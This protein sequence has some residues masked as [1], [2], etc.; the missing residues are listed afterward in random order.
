[1]TKTPR[2]LFSIGIDLGTSNCAL[3]YIDLAEWASAPSAEGK[4][5]FPDPPGPPRSLSQILEIPQWE[6][7]S[8]SVTRKI[9]PSFALIGGADG[10]DLPPSAS[11]PVVGVL[12]RDLSTR[13]PGRIIASAKSW[14]THAGVDRRAKILPWRSLEIPKEQ[15][16]SP[17]EASAL[18]LRYLR[19]TWDREMEERARQ[20]GR[21][22]AACRF[23]RQHIVITVP[24]SF[25][26]AA[27]KLTLEAAK[28]AGYPAA[29]R[30]LEEP[31]AA[32][33]AW[34][35]R[36]REPDALK[37]ALEGTGSRLAPGPVPE[38]GPRAFH[39]LVVDIGGGT[40]DFSLFEVAFPDAAAGAESASLQI[41]RM[42]VSDHI[43]LGGDNIDLAIAHALEAG[44]SG[45]EGGEDPLDPRSWQKLVGESRRLK[46]KALES[47]DPEARYQVGL[48]G[49]G[50][51]LFAAAKTLSLSGRDLLHLVDEGFFPL[52]ALSEGPRGE[53]GGFRE[54]GLPY[55]RDSAITRHLAAFLQGFLGAPE[56]EP[57]DDIP[58]TALDGILFNGGSLT[59]LSLR[60]RLQGLIAS[61]QGGR[62]P[63]LLDNPE[64]DL[65]VAR[66]AASYGRY[67][68][69]EAGAPIEA[70]SA[71]G[72]YLAVSTPSRVEDRYVVCILPLG[73]EAGKAFALDKLDLKLAV[74]RPVEFRL[75]SS[76][77]RRR[78][79]AGMLLRA[80]GPAS[81]GFTELPP[82]RTVARLDAADLKN[83][84]RKYRQ[85]K[86]GSLSSGGPASGGALPSE[87][88]VIL[89]SSLNNLGLLQ[90]FLEP[91]GKGWPEALRWELEF[92]LRARDLAEP[93]SDGNREGTDTALSTGSDLPD[94]AVPSIPEPAE[95]S[96]PKSGGPRQKPPGAPAIPAEARLSPAQR[97]SARLLL[98][99]PFRLG[100]L[101]QLEEIAG[102]KRAAW[103]RAWLRFFFEPLTAWIGRRNTGPEEEAAWLN[104]AGF[105]L[106]PGFGVLLDDFRL[107]QLWQVQGDGLAYPRDRG[108]RD[109][110]WLLWRRVAG[111]LDAK[112]QALLFS[113][114]LPL[115][116]TRNRQADEAAGMAASLER[117]PLEDRLRL[118]DALL[119][120]I[121]DKGEGHLG[122]AYWALGRLLSRVSLAGGEESLLPPEAVEKAFTAMDGRDFADPR[123]APL[124]AVFAQGCRITRNRTVDVPSRLRERVLIKM[125]EAGA[126]AAQMKP[127]REFVPVA[128]DDLNQLFGEA[129]PLGL[130][131]GRFGAPA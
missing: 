121:A 56:A 22:P 75:F 109:Q 106:R 113:E 54:M 9:L 122:H 35:E 58:P 115:L 81:A 4:A 48:S 116:E 101:K 126:P 28:L 1:M 15:K 33:H 77:R 112:R 39:V 111:G 24:A 32:F 43:L 93:A 91:A 52:C 27:Q 11:G 61:W 18:Y 6:T 76:N 68:A 96:A 38:E 103:P 49:P 87:I 100:M 37:K 110:Y 78:D 119:R 67:P 10:A 12:A 102:R 63:V 70:G 50:G 125:E 129:L 89:R 72:F 17:V 130:A 97:E 127:L 120:F 86:G 31:Q 65:A 36:H 44:R 83:F 128:Q 79:H 74:N 104:A 117:L 131:I 21:N 8:R 85:G 19:E 47:P 114:A 20:A 105:F 45:G 82:V 98:E 99:K 23:D 95:A 40:S 14:L 53:K 26:Q 29:V 84:A 3:S 123:H 124:L 42:A 94:S 69:S 60:E 41:R 90:I 107:D 2:Y 7:P 66:G 51:S 57:D 73:A 92:D 62:V 30:L 5:A 13:E 16:L 59:P 80:S 108:V 55:A 88:P 25:D 64:L 71:Q 46:E 118:L 34:L